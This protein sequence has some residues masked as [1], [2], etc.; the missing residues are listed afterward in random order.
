[1]ECIQFGRRLVAVLCYPALIIRITGFRRI[2]GLRQAIFFTL[3]R[4]QR[5]LTYVNIKIM[6]F[7]QSFLY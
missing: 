4:S 5:N 2:E 7:L 3:F 6:M 1:M